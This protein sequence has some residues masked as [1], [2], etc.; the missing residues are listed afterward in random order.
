MR[1]TGARN[2][3]WR[4]STMAHVWITHLGMTGR[5]SIIGAKQQPG[6]FY[7]AEPPDPTHTH[8]VIEM[9]EGARL[10]FNDPRRF[11]YM[12][13]IAEDELETHPFFKGMGP[14]PLGNRISS[15]RI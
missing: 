11:G 12:D 8:V 1:W 3:C 10:E 2:I 6:D 7:Y 13:L 14:E 9:E 15:R 5:W 4:I